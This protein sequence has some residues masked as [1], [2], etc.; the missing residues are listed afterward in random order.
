MFRIFSSLSRLLSFASV[1]FVVFGCAGMHSVTALPSATLDRGNFKYVRPVEAT[2]SAVYVFGIGG[3]SGRAREENAYNKMMEEANLGPNQTIVN[4]SFRKNTHLYFPLGVF[5]TSVTTRVSGW[6]VEFLDG[7]D[8][9]GSV[10][11]PRNDSS[12]LQHT[13]HNMQQNVNDELGKLVTFPDGSSGICFYVD[14]SG[15]GLVVSLDQTR[16]A[17]DIRKGRSLEDIESIPRFTGLGKLEIGLGKTYSEAILSHV[18]SENAKAVDWCTSHGYD[19]YLPSAEELHQLMSI[20]NKGHK[21]N[22]RISKALV[23]N[24]GVALEREWYWSS[25][26]DDRDEAINVFY[27]GTTASDRKN[28]TLLVRAVRAF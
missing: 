3:M 14:Q 18:H 17:W 11:S 4:V 26:E 16:L 5:C 25:S 21:R 1:M 22:G 10:N 8:V 13:E 12:I 6:V 28:L 23:E 27:N 15:H 20:D 24:G 9:S 7:T 19:W 2:E